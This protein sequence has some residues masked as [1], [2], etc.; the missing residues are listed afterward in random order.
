MKSELLAKS[1]ML[2]L[3]LVA[4]FLFLAIFAV[5]FFVTMKK[6]APA[7]DPVARLP[8]DDEGDRS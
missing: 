7:Y 1:P 5:V 8:L 2:A 4:L 3:P 6:R